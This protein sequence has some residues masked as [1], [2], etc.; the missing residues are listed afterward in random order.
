MRTT[1]EERS[2]NPPG[3]MPSKLTRVSDRIV[4]EMTEQIEADPNLSTELRSTGVLRLAWR[5]VRVALVVSLCTVLSRASDATCGPWRAQHDQDPGQSR[6]RARHSP[7]ITPIPAGQMGCGACTTSTPRTFIAVIPRKQ[8][9]SSRAPSRAP[10][11]EINLPRAV[12]KRHPSTQDLRSWRRSRRRQPASQAG[13]F[14]RPAVAEAAAT[15]PK[16]HRQK[17]RRKAVPLPV[18]QNT[19]ALMRASGE[20]VTGP[21]LAERLGC[22]E[23]SGYRY[24]GAIP[25]VA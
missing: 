3:L 20:K 14:R 9:G 18:V 22:S 11:R 10:G 1:D 13:A 15:E 25:C 7:T 2:L 6:T 21:T 12:A 4:T 16:P 19:I 23:R 17:T 24:L 8:L 5:V